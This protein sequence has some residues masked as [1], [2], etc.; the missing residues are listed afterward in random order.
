ML[1]VEQELLM[2]VLGFMVKFRLIIIKGT[3]VECME[4]LNKDV[5]RKGQILYI[6]G[7]DNEI[8]TSANLLDIKYKFYEFSC[9]LIETNI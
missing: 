2:L 6:G 1:Q 8:A 3:S 9:D 5:K 7:R 4:F